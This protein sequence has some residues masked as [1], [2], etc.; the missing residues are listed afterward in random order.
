MTHHISP[1]LPHGEPMGMHG[2]TLPHA[3]S[4]DPQNINPQI[5]SMGKNYIS[6]PIPLCSSRNTFPNP[7]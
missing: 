6:I 5:P 7:S 1:I 2:E 3:Q 4:I